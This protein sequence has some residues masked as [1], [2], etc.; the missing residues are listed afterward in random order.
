MVRNY[1][2]KTNSYSAVPTNVPTVEERARPTETL[3]ASAHSTIV[4]S[5]KEAAQELFFF[6][7]R[8]QNYAPVLNPVM[9]RKQKKSIRTTDQI[10]L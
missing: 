7:L 10:H 3:E 9:V 2:R 1:K 8:K 6:D 5:E 4:I